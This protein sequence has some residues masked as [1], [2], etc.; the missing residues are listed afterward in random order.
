MSLYLRSYEAADYD[1][2]ASMS[3]RFLQETRNAFSLVT[4]LN[5][6]RMLKSIR[7]QYQYGND[8]SE[9]KAWIYY[10]RERN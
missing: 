7:S 6:K 10:F 2:L 5:E 9:R 1:V 8:Q 4:Q 3:N